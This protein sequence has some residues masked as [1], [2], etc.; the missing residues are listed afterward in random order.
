MLLTKK[1]FR[2][3]IMPCAGPLNPPIWGTK[4][5]DSS[6]SP[7]LGDLGGECRDA[8]IFSKSFY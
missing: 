4:V 3:I 8:S 5:K 6:K 1:L 7:I 2:K